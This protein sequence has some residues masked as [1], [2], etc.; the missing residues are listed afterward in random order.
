MDSTSIPSSHT[1][2]AKRSTSSFDL[3]P[4]LV[5]REI[6]VLREA[7]DAIFAR[8]SPQQPAGLALAGQRAIETAQ[9][10][11]ADEVAQNEHVERN[12][13]ALLG[14]DLLGGVRVLPRLVVLDDSARTERV[15]VDAIDL[16]GQRRPLGELEPPLE[17]RCG[18]LRSE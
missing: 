13:Q 16:A 11:D 4:E 2:R 8:F 5:L 3:A 1:A 7:G 15:D 9:R 6:V 10:L 18:A 12:L 17:L 14:L